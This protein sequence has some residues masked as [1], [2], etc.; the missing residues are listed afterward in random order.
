MN[1][2][3]VLFGLSF[4]SDYPGSPL[5]F[6]IAAFAAMILFLYHPTLALNLIN[7]HSTT[8]PI[9][10]SGKHWGSSSWTDGTKPVLRILSTSSAWYQC[11]TRELFI[12]FMP[13]GEYVRSWLPRD[14]VHVE[15]IDSPS[16]SVRSS[17]YGLLYSSQDL[18]ALGSHV[19]SP[20]TTMLVFRYPH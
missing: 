11:N 17:P 3:N 15:S 2:N 13:V 1:R 16:L 6:L 12:A 5:H 7:R 8:I 20:S 19:S 9:H 14:G 10:C 18:W 4:R